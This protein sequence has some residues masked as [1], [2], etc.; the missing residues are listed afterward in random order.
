MMEN[1]LVSEKMYLPKLGRMLWNSQRRK[2][3]NL[4]KGSI[5]KW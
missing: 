4:D 5:E 2:M 3:R 1:Q